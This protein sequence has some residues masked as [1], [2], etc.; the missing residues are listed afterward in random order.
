MTYIVKDECIKCKHT[1]CVELAKPGQIV[2]NMKA[3]L[4]AIIPTKNVLIV[5]CANR[6]CPVD[7]IVA[8]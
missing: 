5:A 2:L 3:K 1:D 8:D 6:F 4:L 7:A